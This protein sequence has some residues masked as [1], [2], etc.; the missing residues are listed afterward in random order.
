MEHDQEEEKNRSALQFTL[1]WRVEENVNG[2]VFAKG[3]CLIYV[4]AVVKLQTITH[5]FW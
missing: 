3:K 1:Y 5:S 2:K 4:I